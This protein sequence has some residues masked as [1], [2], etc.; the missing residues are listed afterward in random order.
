MNRKKVMR[1]GSERG[2]NDLESRGQNVSMEGDFHQKNKK[3]SIFEATDKTAFTKEGNHRLLLSEFFFNHLIKKI[4]IMKCRMK[5]NKLSILALSI[6]IIGDDIS[7]KSSNVK[8]NINNICN[9]INHTK[10]AILIKKLINCKLHFT[11]R[12]N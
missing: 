10:R 12:L 1:V 2:K 3:F 7:I 11:F 5:H 8:F 6:T 9:L 4:S